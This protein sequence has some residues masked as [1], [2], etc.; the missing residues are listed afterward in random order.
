MHETE[1]FSLHAWEGFYLIVGA[2][3]GALT[4]LQFVVM[5]LIS[6]SGRVRSGQETLSAFGTPNVVHFCAALLLS[7]I[8]TA[9][10]PGPLPAGVA[11]ALCGLA[12]LVYTVSVFRTARRQRDYRPVL[13]DW[14]WHVTLPLL[15]YAA[16]VAAGFRLPLEAA[17]FA[18]GGATLL[19]VFIGVHN[20]W[21]T[22]TYVMVTRD[23][24]RS[25]RGVSAA[26]SPREAPRPSSPGASRPAPAGADRSDSES[27]RSGA[28]RPD[29][30]RPGSGGPSAP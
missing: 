27:A 9:P 28:P 6:E 16:L 26:P 8:M 17:T 11:L 20:A 1:A 7:A 4:G 10:W 13:E 18:V 2:A 3:A 25:G 19:L 14:V 12:G 5:T 30:A 24:E 23:R 15:A 29:D 22:V 21:D